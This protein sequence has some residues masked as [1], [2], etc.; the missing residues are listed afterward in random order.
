MIQHYCKIAF[1]NII[2]K[3]KT[4]SIIS[5]IGLAV[6]FTC[7]ALSNLWIHYEITYDKF[8]EGV[9][10]THLLYQE[11]TFSES[12]FSTYSS[13]MLATTLRQEFPEVEAACAVYQRETGLKTKE[14][15]TAKVNCMYAD[16]T[17]LEM[18]QPTSILSGNMEF[19]YSDNKIALT[20]E[21][22]MSL[23]GSTEV[24]GEELE[25]DDT[26]KTVCAI[27][28]NGEKHS[29]LYFAAWTMSSQFQKVKSEWGV[30]RFQTYVRLRKGV[31]ATSFQ[32]KMKNYE[33]GNQ[34]YS[35][36]FEKYKI[37]PLTQYHY[38]AIN[39][40]L[41]LKFNYLVLFSIAS[42]MIILCALF[43]YLSLFITRMRARNREIELRKV[44]GSSIR[45]LF[46]LFGAEYLFVLLL[47]GLLGMTF[48]ELSLPKFRE[49]S[50]INGD[51]YGESFLYFTGIL[52]ISYILLT[53]F[54]VR[55]YHR[56]SGSL[57]L[58]RKCSIVFQ[59]IICILFIFCV[60][61]LMKQL[62]HLANG[63]I[64]WERKNTAVLRQ[65]VSPE[66]Y[67]A[68]S[69]EID[70]MP[71]IV[72]TLKGCEPLFPRYSTLTYRINSWEGKKSTDQ[73]DR[74]DITCIREGREFINFY[75]L[76]LIEG[77][78]LK[79]D[80]ADKAIINET[81]ARKL[82]LDNPIGKK[83]NIH[84][85][86][87][88]VGI[89]KD[90]HITAPTIPAV[91]TLFCNK[92]GLGGSDSDANYGDIL[93]KYRA[94]TWEDLKKRVDDVYAKISTGSNEYHSLLNIEEE[95]SKFLKSETLLLKLLGFASIIC[96]LI[97]AFG[98]F[99]FI[100]LSCEQRRKEIAIRKVNG[101]S[102]KEIFAMFVKEYFILLVA[103]SVL[104]FPIGYA[105]MKK[106]LESYIE[107][108]AI[109]AW[110]YLAIFSGVALLILLCIGWRVW[111]AARQNPAEVIKSE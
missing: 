48:I 58:F 51:I 33:S 49:L 19:L 76:K 23:F 24:L 61:I 34:W 42:G 78:M 30:H 5:I 41:A 102:V 43:N 71:C 89:V 91:P 52:F 82:G 105:L 13:Y 38:S 2:L 70:K 32:E 85:G 12:T 97:A 36:P 80:D 8:Y 46:I 11:A 84:Q 108:T 16:S 69:A 29:N 56:Q 100:T 35:K 57:F 44:C 87:T 10:R 39:E 79:P 59:L 4:Q 93:I 55:R 25:T 21:T 54:I 20:E 62:N 3:Y 18:F 88:I 95:Y 103:A 64:G 90:F 27:L 94:G 107:Q 109:S 98:I 60:S 99:S 96:V 65:Y 67:A 104:A 37:I 86:V 81:C 50:E 73:E 47:S 14:G 111:Q 28:K 53:P 74:I 101:A 110:I 45:N 26:P 6:G 77:E 15:K 7:F 92:G 40:K 75:N 22:A 1:R 83:I 17:F 72:E 68:V 106:W 31:D 63:D 9:E 66:S